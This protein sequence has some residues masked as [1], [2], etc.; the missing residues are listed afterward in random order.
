MRIVRSLATLAVLAV[1]A[2]LALGSRSVEAC[3]RILGTVLGFTSFPADGAIGVPLNATPFVTG[4][5]EG[6]RL[7]AADLDVEVAASV[8]TIEVKGEFGRAEILA[9][10]VPAEALSALT[11]YE[12]RREEVTIATFGTGSGI[13]DAA[14]GAPTADV[15]ERVAAEEDT[16]GFSCAFDGFAVLVVDGEDG[17]LIV[18]AFDEDVAIDS[19]WSGASTTDTLTVFSPEPIDLRV[20]V[21]DLAGNISPSTQ[22]D[23]EIPS[24]SCGGC[25][26]PSSST[27]SALSVLWLLALSAGRNA[28]CRRASAP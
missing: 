15:T 1:L 23:V 7:F 26:S 2:V 3:D 8:E 25:S 18:G 21:V 6:L 13:D 22:L 24:A 12:L 5:P 9:R 28:R 20:A 16:T 10:L 19:T 17:G 27:S 4:A 14:P 11:V